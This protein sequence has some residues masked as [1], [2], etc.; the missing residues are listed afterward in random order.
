MAA[1]RTQCGACAPSGTEPSGEAAGGGGRVPSARAPRVETPGVSSGLPGL[2]A[3][4][5]DLKA[6]AD[7]KSG[8][9]D[10]AGRGSLPPWQPRFT[11]E[12]EEL[13][14]ARGARP[15][16]RDGSGFAGW[17]G[18]GGGEAS[19]LLK[20][21]PGAL[22]PRSPTAPVSP[23]WRAGRRAPLSPETFG[24]ALC[25]EGARRSGPPPPARRTPARTPASRLQGLAGILG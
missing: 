14:Q 4:G 16:N 8:S 2:A 7:P 11:E 13:F 25:G 17:G 24:R 10:P 22:T 15:G 1:E 18:G 20:R 19:R 3:L 5:V 9:Q 23:P 6:R 21:E 12:E